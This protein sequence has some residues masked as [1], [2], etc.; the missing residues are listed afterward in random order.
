MLKLAA[1]YIIALSESEDIKSVI[2]NFCNFWGYSG[3]N[4]KNFLKLKIESV[5]SKKYDSLSSTMTFAFL[6]F[7]S[8]SL[9]WAIAEKDC[10]V[11]PL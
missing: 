2:F 8:T 11:K 4:F 3:E 6:R 5:L 7:S 9:S 1:I 10:A